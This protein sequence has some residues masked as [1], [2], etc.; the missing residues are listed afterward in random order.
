MLEPL[1]RRVWDPGA[2]AGPALLSLCLA[3]LGAA[4]E[5]AWRL[6]EKILRHPARLPVP[7]VS[8][9]ALTA[10]GTGKTPVAAEV[11]RTLMAAGV[12]VALLSRGYGRAGG[13]KLL[14]A[15][16][17]EGNLADA[18]EAGDE[19]AM[20]ARALPGLV[21][22]VCADRARG[23]ALAVSRYGAGALLLDDGFQ[24]RRVAKDLDIVTVNGRSPFGNGRML[25]AGPLRMPASALSRAGLVIITKLAS[26]D[27]PAPVRAMLGAM[28][29]GAPLLEARTVPVAF[30][31]LS[32][33]KPLPLDAMRRRRVAAMCALAEPE[34]FVE[35]LEEQG[36]E[37]A[38]RFF[39]PDH[40]RYAR[41]DIA[42]VRD[43]AHAVEAIVTTEKDAVKIDPE[44]LGGGP[45]LLALSVRTE[46]D[47]REAFEGAVRRAAG[48]SA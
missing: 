4:Y 27:D 48:V 23:G 34:L 29:P 25:P 36:I 24:N 7:V 42:S 38:G 46:F 12:R 2:S 39:F 45:P 22:I 40:H 16:D 19:P 10:G 35:G 28:A 20:L 47:D 33:G 8:V 14:V 30:R 17:G 43:R 13:G 3:P 26:E 1:A 37:V 41:A 11:A 32:T 5:V 15:S 18:S 31:D 21:A 44:W 6:R 9:G